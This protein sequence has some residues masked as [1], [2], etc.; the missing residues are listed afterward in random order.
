VL[1]SVSPLSKS[2]VVKKTYYQN[3]GRLQHGCFLKP[4]FHQSTTKTRQMAILEVQKLW[5]SIWCVFRPWQSNSA[6]TVT[7]FIGS[8]ETLNRYKVLEGPYMCPCW[9]AL[10][11]DKKRRIEG[12]TCWNFRNFRSVCEE[13]PSQQWLLLASP[14]LHDYASWGKGTC[15]N[16]KAAIDRFD[17]ISTDDFMTKIINMTTMRVVDLYDIV[18]VDKKWF[19]T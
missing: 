4:A 10:W 16:A 13:L 2:W 5:I 14:W 11:G 3:T 8:V 12:Q 18:K 6:Y 7:P 17:W 1:L 19:Y 15:N 9:S